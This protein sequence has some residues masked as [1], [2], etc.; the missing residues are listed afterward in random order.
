M[1]KKRARSIVHAFTDSISCWKF[2]S[3]FKFTSRTVL[4][5]VKFWIQVQLQ[6]LIFTEFRFETQIRE[7]GTETSYCSTQIL[8]LSLSSQKNFSSPL[9][10]FLQAHDLVTAGIELFPYLIDKCPS[11]GTKAARTISIEPKTNWPSELATSTPQSCIPEQ[12]RLRS[13]QLQIKFN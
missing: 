1:K 2:C 11:L 6:L 7:G 12:W 5:T 3:E 10:R 9:A 13:M 4:F 8:V